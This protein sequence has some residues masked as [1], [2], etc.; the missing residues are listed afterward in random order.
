MMKNPFILPAF[1]GR[2]K[3]LQKIC[4]YLL[5][6]PLQNCPIIGETFIGKTTLL[7]AFIDSDGPQLVN[8]LNLRVKLTFVYWDGISY[9]G[10]AILVEYI[11]GQFCWDLC[12]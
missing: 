11:S 7:R 2:R 4:N 8:E 6:H 9:F 1:W 5:S 12:A 3:E 10:W